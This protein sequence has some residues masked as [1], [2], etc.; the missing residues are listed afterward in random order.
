MRCVPSQSHVMNSKDGKLSFVRRTSRTAW[1][2]TE[3]Q[4]SLSM[5]KNKIINLPTTSTKTKGRNWKRG[6]TE[7][8]QDT[9]KY[10]V[11]TGAF[12]LLLW[13]SSNQLSSDKFLSH[14]VFPATLSLKQTALLG[15]D[16]HPNAAKNS[17]SSSPPNLPVSCTN[18]RSV[19]REICKENFWCCV[20]SCMI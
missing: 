9:K 5:Q 3:Q 4:F 15:I 8:T 20:R 12:F 6:K 19:K 11:D 2:Q 13:V 7:N 1:K 14:G 18:D 10:Q 16:L 17:A